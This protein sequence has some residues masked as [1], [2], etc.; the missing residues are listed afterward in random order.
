VVRR[1]HKQ[2]EKKAG[3]D[4]TI[5]CSWQAGEENVLETTKWP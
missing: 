1:V 2:Q 5:I 4:T 3:V